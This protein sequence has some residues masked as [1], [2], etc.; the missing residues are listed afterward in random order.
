MNY[1]NFQQFADHWNQSVNCNLPYGNGRSCAEGWSNGAAYGYKW[2]DWNSSISCRMGAEY[3]R[4]GDDCCD[5]TGVNKCPRGSDFDDYFY[6]DSGNCVNGKGWICTGISNDCSDYQGV[7]EGQSYTLAKVFELDTSSTSYSSTW[8]PTE[9]P[10]PVPTSLPTSAPSFAPT[11]S[12][13]TQAPTN[14]T[15]RRLF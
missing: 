13:P 12:A 15:T 1:S 3:L 9:T 2:L 6:D 10:T 8:A 4:G 11:T 7:F 5:E 14:T